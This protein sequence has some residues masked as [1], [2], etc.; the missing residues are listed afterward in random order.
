MHS[1][2]KLGRIVREQSQNR[3]GFRRLLL[4]LHLGRRTRLDEFWL[5][6]FFIRSGECDVVAFVPRV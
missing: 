6:L 2:W 5:G 3:K 1:S 4:F